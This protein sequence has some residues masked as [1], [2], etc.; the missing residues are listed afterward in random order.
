MKSAAPQLSLFGGLD[1]PSICN[2]GYSPTDCLLSLIHHLVR[3]FVDTIG[4]FLGSEITLYSIED[5]RVNDLVRKL[6]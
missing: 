4:S 1:M 6:I 2:R 3:G 5:R